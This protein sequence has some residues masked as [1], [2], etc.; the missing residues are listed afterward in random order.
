MLLKEQIKPKQRELKKLQVDM[1]GIVKIANEQKRDMNAEEK[2]KFDRMYEDFE[3]LQEKVEKAMTMYEDI[4]VK[5]ENDDDDKKDDPY[6]DDYA[7]HYIKGMTPER[8]RDFNLYGDRRG[9][10]TN[11]PEYRAMFN[12]FLKGNVEPQKLRDYTKRSFQAGSLSS[13][14]AVLLPEILSSFILRNAIATKHVLR[15]SRKIPLDNAV[16]LGVPSLDSYVPADGWS[17][18]IDTK[19]PGVSPTF[20]KRKLEPSLHRLIT[21]ASR[22]FIDL[23]PTNAEYFD[24]ND[25]EYNMGGSEG[26]IYDE[27]QRAAGDQLETAL[28]T[29]DGIGKPLGVFTP[30]AQGISTARDVVT[31]SATG[32]TYPGLVNAVMGVVEQY[33]KDAKWL[34]SSEFVKRVMQLVD[35]N[36]RPLLDI[37]TMPGI[38]MMLLG[39]PV[40]RS[41]YTPS[42]FSSNAYVGL[43]G[44]FK[45]IFYAYRK[46][47][48]II[49]AEQTYIESDE[50]GFFLRNYA[51]AMPMKEE[52]FARLKC[53]P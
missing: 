29:G 42:T 41:E 38:P 36:N 8:K 34:V 52:A 31:G 35:S 26:I 13:G 12:D 39:H 37:N 14:G 15:E 19:T 53:G 47:L 48:E 21:K 9:I 16:S 30:S 44:D 1:Q 25:S 18:E 24:N 10:S 11:H 23:L 5:E 22:T 32:I 3:E 7:R 2:E 27:M 49:R 20:S 17:G 28:Q 4:K 45:Y 6:S 51:D 40:M 50:V 46:Q 33:T 43:F